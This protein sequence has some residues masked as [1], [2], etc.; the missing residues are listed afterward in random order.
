MGRN[1]ARAG[2]PTAGH[3]RQGVHRYKAAE[4]NS[5][6]RGAIYVCMWGVVQHRRMHINLANPRNRQGFNLL[7]LERKNRDP[8]VQ[9]WLDRGGG[10]PPCPKSKHCGGKGGARLHVLGGRRAACWL[11]LSA[12]AAATWVGECSI[13]GL[14]GIGASSPAWNA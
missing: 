2:M 11:L 14:L 9:G 4:K 10:G 1:A 7:L 13:K 3:A 12:G 5:S 8:S 6:G